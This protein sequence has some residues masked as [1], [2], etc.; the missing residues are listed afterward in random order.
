MSRQEIQIEKRFHALPPEAQRQVLDFLASLE[1]RYRPASPRPKTKPLRA[2]AFVGL[3][4][5][6]ED[7]SDSARWVR[8]L[9]HQ[10]WGK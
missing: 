9:R 4:R 3:W 8:R 10:E 2:Y 1:Q 5:G 7:L 6:R